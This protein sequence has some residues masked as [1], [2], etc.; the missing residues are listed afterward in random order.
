MDNANSEFSLTTVS[1]GGSGGISDIVEDSSPQLG[2]DLDVNGNKI[3][4]DSNNDNVIIDPHGTGAL[5]LGFEVVKVQSPLVVT[6]IL[7]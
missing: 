1:S 7:N 6:M 5:Q 3:V 2:G 4:T